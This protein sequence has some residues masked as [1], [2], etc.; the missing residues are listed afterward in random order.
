MTIAA[1]RVTVA[2]ASCDGC[3]VC[4]AS[5]PTGAVAV[6]GF[7]GLRVTPAVPVR[8]ECRRVSVADAGTEAIRVPC[9]GGLT[10][11]ALFG[12][13]LRDR[14]NI[15]IV[16]RGWCRSCA[17]AAGSAA[18]W[19][20][21]VTAVNRLVRLASG[22][23][24]PAIAVTSSPLSPRSALDLPRPEPGPTVSRRDLFA[25]IGAP[26]KSKHVPTSADPAH[27]PIAKVAT[28]TLTVRRDRLSTLSRGRPLA[29]ALFPSAS[30]AANC[31]DNQV[32][33]RSCPTAALSIVDSPDVTGLDFD[34]A[35]CIACGA[36]KTACPTG[37]V[38]VAPAGE[39]LYSGP[40]ALRRLPRVVCRACEREFVARTGQTICPA[41][42]KD[43]DLAAAGLALVRR[44]KLE[45]SEA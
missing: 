2:E 24:S 40:V 41:C 20:P 42:H 45:K 14:V 22:V 11:D 39:G 9:L 29:A 8:L 5:C 35:L 36:C 17:A 15:T 25:R 21:S 12:L 23:A 1:R 3:G 38:A 44:R 6:E 33:A 28:D 30:I 7:S 26:A 19:S 4:A 34:A 13:A 31:C 43:R 10:V 37:S 18:P 32:C 16:D 27:K